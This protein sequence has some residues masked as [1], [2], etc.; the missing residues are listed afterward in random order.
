MIPYCM[1]L[2]C[3]TT[4]SA[5]VTP[6]SIGPG[7]WSCI[8]A[9]IWSCGLVGFDWY[10][11]SV[12]NFGPSGGGWAAGRRWGRKVERRREL[13]RFCRGLARGK[14]DLRL[15]YAVC[16]RHSTR[17]TSVPRIVKL[18]YDRCRGASVMEGVL[19]L[20]GLFVCCIAHIFIS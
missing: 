4:P 20:L 2:N 8:V 11:S 15:Y 16:Y 10:G 13:C 19:F 17:Q 7:G 18:Q 6:C 3:A 9:N 5:T 14:A 12:R 1:P